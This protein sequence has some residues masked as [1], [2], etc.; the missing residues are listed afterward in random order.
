MPS[1]GTKKWSGSWTRKK[2]EFSARG[3]HL[4]I[5]GLSL[6]MSVKI[7]LHREMYGTFD[8]PKNL[9]AGDV[10]EE[11]CPSDQYVESLM[12]FEDEM[13]GGAGWYTVTFD[14]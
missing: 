14:L 4:I 3:P 6:T 12:L 7:V 1:F 10:D 5:T 9:T 8:S 2:K 11:G 13:E